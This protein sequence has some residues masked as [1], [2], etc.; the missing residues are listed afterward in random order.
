M[1]KDIIVP[2]NIKDPKYR[3]Y[4]EHL[5]EIIDKQNKEISVKSQLFQIQNLNFHRELADLV[6]ELLALLW[7]DQFNSIRI[8]IKEYEGQTGELIFSGGIGNKNDSYAYLD[9]QVEEQLGEPGIFYILDTS[10]IHSIKFVPGNNF[11][12][13]ILGISLGEAKETQGFVWFA[14]E[15]QKN[16]T[17]HESDSLFSL[18]GACL[19]NDQELHRMEWKNKITFI[20]K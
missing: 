1:N 6:G 9:V 15:D 20:S 16:F 13:T 5:H 4:F 2:E 10:K 7:N 11:P 17:K 18:I 12:K 8:I 19:C 3:E 14:C